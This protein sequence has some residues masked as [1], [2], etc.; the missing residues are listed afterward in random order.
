MY[1]YWYDEK[2][3]KSSG[4]QCKKWSDVD[5]ETSIKKYM[6]SLGEDDYESEYI[7]NPKTG[8]YEDVK[9]EDYEKLH[10]LTDEWRKQE[11][12]IDDEYNKKRNSIIHSDDNY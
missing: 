4:K 5:P 3:D 2:N 10:R 8:S 9:G 12:S 1:E 11:E 6:D 7:E